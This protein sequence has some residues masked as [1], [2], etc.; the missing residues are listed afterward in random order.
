[1]KRFEDCDCAIGLGIDWRRGAAVRRER[2]QRG[3]HHAQFDRWLEDRYALRTKDVRRFARDWTVVNLW[4]A[5]HSKL[6][7]LMAVQ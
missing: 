1:M 5:V 3:Y 6:W 7:W 2:Y 4:D